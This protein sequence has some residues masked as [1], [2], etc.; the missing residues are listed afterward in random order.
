M[1]A[2]HFDKLLRLG[3]RA[4]QAASVLDG[5]ERIVATVDNQQPWAAG[6]ACSKAVLDSRLAERLSCVVNAKE[7][8]SCTE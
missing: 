2:S 5:I 8:V 1:I 7:L 6:V 3:S 4:E